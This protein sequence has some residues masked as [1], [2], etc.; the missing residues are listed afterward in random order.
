[1]SIWYSQIN[2][3]KAYLKIERSLSDNTIEGYIEDINK[4]YQFLESNYDAVL[5]QKVK[6]IHIR[7]FLHFVTEMGLA[8][9]SQNRILSGVKSFFKYLLLE[10]LIDSSPAEL[11][12]TARVGRKL[13]D[14]LNNEEV[15]LLLNQVDRSKPEGERNI[16]II[17]VLYGCGLRVSELVNLK[18]SNIFFEDDFIRVTG[19]GDKQR[20]VPL[21][22]MAKKHIKLYMNEIRIHLYIQKGHEDFLFLNRRGKQLT[23]VMI[24]TIIKNLAELAGIKKTISPHTLRHSFATELLQRGA[25]LRAIQD[26][27]GHESI[28]TTEIYTHLNQ[29]DLLDTIIQFHP[30]S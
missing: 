24:F 30:R 27:L 18:I 11:I 6:P 13:P 4:L 20:L 14:T 15:E 21:G 3:F 8:I 12:E 26:M 25:D 7:E 28:T 2:E 16:A 22:G 10:D 5:P 23:R 1:M 17:E 19:K 9:S 29:A